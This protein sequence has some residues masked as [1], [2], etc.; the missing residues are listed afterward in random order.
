MTRA[1]RLAP[2]RAW[3]IIPTSDAL[4]W[5]PQVRRTS[6]VFPVGR[7]F[8]S[9]P[10]PA[11]DLVHGALAK[12]TQ[13]PSTFLAGAVRKRR[14]YA[15]N[16]CMM[17]DVAHFPALCA[18]SR[19]FPGEGLATFPF[20]KALFL[21]AAQRTQPCS[22]THRVSKRSRRFPS[23]VLCTTGAPRFSPPTPFPPPA[24]PRVGQ[25]AGQQK[26]VSLHRLQLKS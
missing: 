16:A 21:H 6:P 26:K 20:C 5:W 7:G 4:G 13:N 24:T 15:R 25:N 12:C 1:F 18:T 3:T 19:L 23:I 10:R 9:M 2:S 17:T 11:S 22:P 8:R 14:S